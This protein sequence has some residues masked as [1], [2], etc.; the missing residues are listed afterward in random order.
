MLALLFA[1]PEGESVLEMVRG[2]PELGEFRILSETPLPEQ[3]VSTELLSET[4][5]SERE[6]GRR[7]CGQQRVR[8]NKVEQVV[9][10]PVETMEEHI[11]V[12]EKENLVKVCGIDGD[13]WQGCHSR[14]AWSR[15][16][17][18]STE[19]SSVGFCRAF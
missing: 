7:I 1:Q 6:V 9:Q 5:V 3:L 10:V 14:S 13:S 17:A 19:P 4:R 18:K 11:M 15:L 8:E 16:C 2:D 12:K